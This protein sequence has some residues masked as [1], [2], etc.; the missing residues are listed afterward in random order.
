MGVILI[1]IPNIIRYSDDK[2]LACVQACHSFDLI[3][4]P[5]GGVHTS[6][7]GWVEVLYN[8]LWFGCVW[9]HHEVFHLSIFESPVGKF[10]VSNHKSK[11]YENC[12]NVFLSEGVERE[13]VGIGVLGI[14][15]VGI[16]LRLCAFSAKGLLKRFFNL[17]NF[18]GNVGS[19]NTMNNGGKIKENQKQKTNF[20]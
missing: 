12:G 16:T 3:F 1:T 5:R 20:C 9:I 17:K 6:K 19:W 18:D 15:V 2:S 8:S 14:F 10:V 7:E 4:E 11:C 13:I